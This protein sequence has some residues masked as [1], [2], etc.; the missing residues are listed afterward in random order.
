VT[1]SLGIVDIRERSMGKESTTVPIFEGKGQ[2]QGVLACTVRQEV[3]RTCI[4][5]APNIWTN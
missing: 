2:L 3:S 5:N 1:T 4:V